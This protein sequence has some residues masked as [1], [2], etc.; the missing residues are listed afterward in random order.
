MERYKALYTRR[1][2]QK[3]KNFIDGFIEV[4]RA[5]DGVQARV[6][7]LDEADAVLVAAMQPASPPTDG[8][9]FTLG[10]FLVQIDSLDSEAP[11]RT[12]EPPPSRAFRV[13]PVVHSGPPARPAAARSEPPPAPRERPRTFDEIIAFFAFTE[14]SG[15]HD[16]STIHSNLARLL[17]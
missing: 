4:C 11:P 8:T 10:G 5:S 13:R 9:N 14:S 2:T 12:P 16:A 7:L 3:A 15:T 17:D 1:I 6:K